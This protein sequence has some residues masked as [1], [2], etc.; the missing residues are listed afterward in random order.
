MGEEG[1]GQR[2]QLAFARRQRLAPLVDDRVEPSGSRSTSSD[3]ADRPDRLVHLVVGGV[4]SG[5]GDV[6][7]DGAGEQERLLGTTPSWLRSDVSVTCEMSC[8][9]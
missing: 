5:E 9:R 8:R 1:P 6:V 4:G 3:E 7:A 2:D